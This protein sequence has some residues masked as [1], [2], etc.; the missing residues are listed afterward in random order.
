MV[1]VYTS[2]KAHF[3]LRDPIQPLVP[4]QAPRK[5]VLIYGSVKLATESRHQS[6]SCDQSPS[7]DQSCSRDQSPSCDQSPDL[8]SLFSDS[9]RV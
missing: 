6:P 3:D 4:K 9:F 2:A 7:N 5:P 1:P 8:A